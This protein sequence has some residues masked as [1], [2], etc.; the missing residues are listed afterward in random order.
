VEVVV[1]TRLLT[2]LTLNVTLLA[3]CSVVGVPDTNPVLA[4]MFIPGGS[5]PALT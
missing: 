1:A 2:S 5:V 4:L 3:D